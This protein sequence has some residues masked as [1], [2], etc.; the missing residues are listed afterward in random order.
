MGPRGAHC[1]VARCEATLVRENIRS[2]AAVCGGGAFAGGF[3]GDLGAAAACIMLHLITVLLFMQFFDFLPGHCPAGHHLAICGRAA[4][5]V[6]QSYTCLAYTGLGVALH[7]APKTGSLRCDHVVTSRRHRRGGAGSSGGSSPGAE[8]RTA[9]SGVKA[10]KTRRHVAQRKARHNAH[11]LR[12]GLPLVLRQAGGPNAVAG[13][14]HAAVVDR[15]HAAQCGGP[16]TDPRDN[17]R[18]C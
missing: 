7:V 3:C 17:A 12:R 15:E 2:H 18:C 10:S 8:L 11:L 9:A 4:R 6:V 5:A 13:R 1:P 16:P 14:L